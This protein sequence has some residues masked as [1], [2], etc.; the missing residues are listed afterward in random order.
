MPIGAA[1]VQIL[2]FYVPSWD[3]YV[4]NLT[5]KQLLTAPKSSQENK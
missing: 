5:K 1:Y 2:H 3:P 4:P